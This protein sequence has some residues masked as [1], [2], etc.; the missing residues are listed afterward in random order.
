[1]YQGS[2]YPLSL[3]DLLHAFQGIE[4]GSTSNPSWARPRGRLP[5]SEVYF[6]EDSESCYP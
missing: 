1:M 2:D 6:G 4:K 3:R 5:F